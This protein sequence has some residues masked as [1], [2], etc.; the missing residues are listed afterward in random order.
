MV[1]YFWIKVEVSFLNI[2]IDI[3][4]TIA[5]TTK[6]ANAILYNENEHLLIQ[7]YH[8]LGKEE[9]KTFVKQHLPEIVKYLIIKDGVAET[10]NYWKDKGYK[11][12]LITARVNSERESLT[13]STEVFLQRNQILYDKIIYKQ[14]QKGKAC[15][16]NDIDIFIDDKE[17]VLDE[18]KSVN[19]N[20]KTIRFLND[21][22]ASKHLTVRSWFDLKR[23]I[24]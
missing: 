17:S 13:P 22:D 23:I 3:D 16:Q 18:I 20:I 7:D 9:F 11:I 24:P 10:I 19:K 1:L 2:G 8:D 4:D 15:W 5:E 6:L 21:P 14:K 12:I